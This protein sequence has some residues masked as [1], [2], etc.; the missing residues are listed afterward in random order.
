M[1][2]AL[3][4]KKTNVMDRRHARAVK[5][6]AGCPVFLVLAGSRESTSRLEDVKESIT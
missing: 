4:F 3:T 6:G 2:T 1:G 5:D